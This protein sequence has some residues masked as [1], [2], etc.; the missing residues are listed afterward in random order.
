MGSL[1]DRV[2]FITGAGA[3][4]GRAAALT[5]AA[6]GARIVAADV[7]EE[8]AQETVGLIEAAGGAGMPL[9]M[10]V[11]EEQQWQAAVSTATSAYG[12]IDV[13]FNN[14]GGGSKADGPVTELD[15]DEFWRT[16]RVDLF[17]TFLGCR[18]VIPVMV[19]NGGGS[20]IN[21]SSLRAVVGTRGADAYTAAKGGVLAASRAMAMQW[22][23]HNIRVNVLAAGIVLTERIKHLI[24]EDDPIYRKMLLGPCEP[25]DV[26]E[27]VLYLA[28]DRSRRVTGA[29]LHLDGGATAY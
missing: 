10:D 29:V 16:I 8:R 22:A 5:L 20:I 17:G 18:T 24:R 12:T 15:L 21:V 2:A 11:T 3:G 7:L 14:A 19:D 23:E 26:A 6:D 1:A 25:E 13:L 27:L 9:A 28:S 4:I